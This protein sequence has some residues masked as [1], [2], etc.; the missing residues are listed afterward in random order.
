MLADIR[1]KV[2][3]LRDDYTTAKAAFLDASIS[4]RAPA[5]S[6]LSDTIWTPTRAGY[7]DDIPSIKATVDANLDAPVS[8]MGAKP[9]VNMAMTFNSSVPLVD[10]R[11]ELD[12]DIPATVK[13][14]GGRFQR[15][16]GIGLHAGAGG[17]QNVLSLTGPGVLQFMAIWA[18]NKSSGTDMGLRLKLDGNVLFSDLTIWNTSGLT[19]DGYLLCGRFGWDTTNEKIHNNLITWDNWVFNTSVE[20]DLYAAAATADHLE[21]SYVWYE[22]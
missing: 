22:T 3:G 15:Y 14:Y 8:T 4:S 11:Q 19:D 21:G 1:N 16:D 20:L 2:A 12:P 17:W 6:A 13:A 7:L 9:P 10:L 18:G 5:S